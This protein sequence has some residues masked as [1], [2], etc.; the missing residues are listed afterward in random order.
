MRRCAILL[1]GRLL[2]A[3]CLRDPTPEERPRG[4]ALQIDHV[5]PRTN[6]GTDSPQNLVPACWECNQARSDGFIEQR[7][8]ALGVSWRSAKRRVARQLHQPL[9]VQGAGLLA[10]QW[11]P[12]LDAYRE[13]TKVL[14]RAWRVRRAEAAIEADAAHSNM[15]LES[16][17]AL[18]FPFGFNAEQEGDL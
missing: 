6:G 10:R 14:V 7:L 16:S 4:R 1:R 12:W 11:Y 18:D 15:E 3:W 5:V 2:C 17:S 8:L 9:N 13:R